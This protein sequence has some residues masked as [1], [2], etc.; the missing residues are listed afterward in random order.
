MIEQHSLFDYSALDTDT[1]TFVQER[2]QA[3]HARLKRTAE[4][5]IA[6][7]Q[8]LI[9]VKQDLDHGQFESWLKTE[10]DMSY[11][12]ALNFMQVAK[13]FGDRPEL[14][15]GNFPFLSVSVLY[16]L[17]APS[18]P[19]TVIDMVKAGKIPPT[20]PAIREA[21]REVQ[22][23]AQETIPAQQA[24]EEIVGVKLPEGVEPIPELVYEQDEFSQ[25][26]PPD[27]LPDGKP[28]D[29]K[30]KRDAHVMEV[31]GSSDSPEWYTPSLV[32]EPVLQLFGEIDLDPCSHSHD[33]PTVPAKTHYTRDDNG[34]DRVWRGKVYMNP[35]YGNEVGKWVEKLVAS[36]ND[37][38]GT[39]EASLS[40]LPG[41]IDTAWFQ[42]L[43]AFPMCNVRGRIQFAN[44][45]Y[46]APFP[47]VIVYMGKDE[48]TFIKIF[49]RLGPIMR[50]VG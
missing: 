8:D 49:R 2:A 27:P 37:G 14:K 42:P 3:I 9:D 50:Q 26:F 23:G 19:D 35:P 17:A 6:I 36:Y 48:D 46:G 41:R 38:D 39:V 5:I 12:T 45:P 31:M 20:I 25:D 15:N 24:I 47:C 13:K 43:Y 1:R 34:L 4:D 44:S 29:A 7:G 28:V 10:F 22:D 30:E 40:L 16:A 21:K 18:T 11:D 33:A 32:I